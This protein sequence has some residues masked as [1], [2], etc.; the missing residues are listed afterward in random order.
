[1]RIGSNAYPEVDV[2]HVVL[3]RAARSNRAH[4]RSLSHDVALANADATEMYERHRV[5]VLGLDGHDLAVRAYRSRERDDSSGWG[6]EERIGFIGNVDAAM[7]SACVGIPT[8]REWREHLPGSRPGPRVCRGRKHGRDRDGEDARDAAHR[9]SFV[10][11]LDNTATVARGADVVNCAYVRES[12]DTDDCGGSR[13][14]ARREQ[15]HRGVSRR[16]QRAGLRLRPLPPSARRTSDPW[17]WAPA[18]A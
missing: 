11:L 16:P 10:C 18:R 7:L 3:A 13:S 6:I 4:G 14:A 12:V 15:P 2:R 1:M 17:R 5:A 8:D 9:S